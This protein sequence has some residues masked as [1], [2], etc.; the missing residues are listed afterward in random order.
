M[1]TG[2]PQYQAPAFHEPD[3]HPR[4][5]DVDME[6]G[7]GPPVGQADSEPKFQMHSFSACPFNMRP[8]SEDPRARLNPRLQWRKVQGVSRASDAGDLESH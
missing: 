6:A 7:G 2:R 8:L 4:L 5:S 1:L 3:A